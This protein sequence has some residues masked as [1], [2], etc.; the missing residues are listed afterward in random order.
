MNHA[1]FVSSLYSRL[2]FLG[3]LRHA[4]L[5]RLSRDFTATYMQDGKYPYMKP[6]DIAMISVGALAILLGLLADIFLPI[7]SIQSRWGV[8]TCLVLFGVAAI[9]EGLWHWI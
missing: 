6:S 8:R 2:S 1:A 5:C 9:S 7:I 3:V 4:R